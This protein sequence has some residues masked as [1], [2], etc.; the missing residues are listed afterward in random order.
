MK[1]FLKVSFKGFFINNN[2]LRYMFI[3]QS[4]IYN[5]KTRGYSLISI[6][7]IQDINLDVL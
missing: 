7:D 2:L 4:P 3:R 5:L 1:L 6:K